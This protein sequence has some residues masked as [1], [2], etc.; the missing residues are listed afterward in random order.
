[1]NYVILA[2]GQGSRFSKE[3]VA[4][5]KPLVPIDGKPMIGR[6]I[7]ILATCGAEKIN[8]SA[9]PRLEGFI[10]YLEELKHTYPGISIR[11]IVTDNSYDSLKAATEGLEGKFIGMTVDAIFPIDEFRA[12][13]EAVEQMDK[14]EVLM[15]LTRYVDDASPLYAR[16]GSDGLVSDYRYGGEPFSEGCIV[17]AGLY[18]I[19]SEAMDAVKHTKGYPESLS[20]FQR[21]L[22]AESPIKVR[23]FEFSTAFDVDNLHDLAEAN[24][25]VNKND[26]TDVR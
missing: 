14:G 3:G 7:E 8:I 24:I 12:Y 18:G 17:S 4:T 11:P 13:V 1:M 21:R 25:F 23:A 20:D 10:P 26:N 22:A 16:L 2:G 9:N 6:L 5:P 19:S 15:G